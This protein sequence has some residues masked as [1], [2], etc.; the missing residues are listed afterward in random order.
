MPL[1]DWNERCGTLRVRAKPAKPATCKKK[2]PEGFPRTKQQRKVC[3]DVIQ[4]KSYIPGQGNLRI[5]QHLPC[6]SAFRVMKDTEV[7]E[8]WKLPLRLRKTSDVNQTC[9]SGGPAWRSGRPLSDAMKVK[10]GLPWIL[11][12]VGD[13]RMRR[14]WSRRGADMVWNQER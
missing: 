4:R 11:E 2:K 7:N 6:G 5:W 3:A 10:S 8:L 9:S 14:S 1:A 13:A 12:D